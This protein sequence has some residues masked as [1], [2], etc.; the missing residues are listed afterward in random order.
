MEN[1]IPIYKEWYNGAKNEIDS[2]IKKYP[3][4]SEYTKVEEIMSHHNK[5]CQMINIEATPTIYVN[6]Y[7]LP[8]WYKVE[9]LKYFVRQ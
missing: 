8:N 3:V 6:G 2:F 7:E 1:S 9:D 5:W 4:E